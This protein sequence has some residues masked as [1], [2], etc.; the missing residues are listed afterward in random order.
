MNWDDTGFLIS[1]NKYNEN[2]LIVEVFTKNH[3]K[4]SGLIFGG[5]S[6]KIKNFLQIG[7]QLFVNFNSKSENRIGYFKIEIHKVYSP[8]FFEEPKKLNCILSAMYLVK[9]LTA[10]AQSNIKIYDL[11]S[12]FYQLLF[13][14]EWLK[15]YIYWELEFLS[16][17]GYKLDLNSMVNKKI[18]DNKIIYTVETITE[19]KIVPNFLINKDE[20]VEELDVLIDG[21]K[22]VGDYMDKTI[23]K[24]NNIN[25]PNTRKQFLQSLK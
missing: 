16:T 9:L 12:S 22:L 23:L 13:D 19:K 17:L 11:I 5:T 24:P 20:K 4:I 1:K 25:F 15:K 8:I 18:H 7:N 6:K 10:E 2:S 3:G 21:L 14:K